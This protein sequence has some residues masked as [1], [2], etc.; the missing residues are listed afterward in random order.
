MAFFSQ[1]YNLA[2]GDFGSLNSALEALLPKKTMPQK[3]LDC[4]PISLI[5]SIAKLSS[6]VLFIRLATQIDNIV[7]PAHSA[8]LKMRCIHHSFLYVHNVSVFTNA[9]SRRCSSRLTLLEPLIPSLGNTCL[10]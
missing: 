3:V 6:K 9:G 2:G 7:L 8:F 10:S 1:V 4:R 5:H